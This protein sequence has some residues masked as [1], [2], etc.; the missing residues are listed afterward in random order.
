MVKLDHPSDEIDHLL[1]LNGQSP[2]EIRFSR[3]KTN[4]LSFDRDSQKFL[5]CKFPRLNEFADQLFP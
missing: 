1:C 5:L 3:A 4:S 2:F